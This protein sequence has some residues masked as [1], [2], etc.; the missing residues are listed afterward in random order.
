MQLLDQEKSSAQLMYSL[1]RSDAR[2]DRKQCGSFRSRTCIF[3]VFV[4]LRICGLSCNVS[5]FASPLN[6]GLLCNLFVCLGV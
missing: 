4:E 1:V 3:A 2:R 6:L 5:A